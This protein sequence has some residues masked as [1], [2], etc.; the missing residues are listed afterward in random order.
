MAHGG[1]CV[2]RQDSLAVFVSGTLPGELVVAEVVARRSKLWFAR[3]VEVVEASP[4][5]VEHVWPLAGRAGVG[6]ADLGHVALT[7]Q[8]RW[9][10]EVV[11][12]QLRRI[13]HLDWAVEVAAAPGDEA[14][15]GLAYRTR[16]DLSADADGRLGM[17]PPRSDRVI[18]LDSM[19]LA[20]EDIVAVV[21]WSKPVAPGSRVRVLR[22]SGLG[23]AVVVRTADD[24]TAGEPA[25]LRRAARLQAADGP[26]GGGVALGGPVGRSAGH[27]GPADS[28]AAQPVTEEVVRAGQR[29]VYRLDPGDFWQ[30]HREAP[31]VLVEAVLDQAGDL[32]GRTVLDLYAGVGLFSVPLAA[33][34]RRLVAV[35]GDRSAALSAAWN[36]RDNP[37][38]T[39][40]QGDV[41]QLL[42][43]SGPVP[44]RA[45]VV[46]LDPPR[47]GAGRAVVEGVAARRPTA[48]VYVACDPA[49]LARDLG[50]FGGLGYRLDRLQAF[51]L[52]PH[53]HH[54]ECVATL[55]PG[56]PSRG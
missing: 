51:D 18:P 50:L 52:F 2:A 47:A 49:A 53:T 34:A 48:V 23:G 8:R 45:D 39:A 42:A 25:P 7:A 14:R 56:P 4:D 30:V 28:G 41:R 31:G 26:S 37:S 54:V 3:T 27:D 12:Q 20:H 43:R 55:S 38:A 11:V 44:A 1:W 40:V 10:A 19:P 36:L 13:A 46:V 21:P 29:L 6:G 16:L 33:A 5:R 22:T 35:E 24:P 9:K 17:H 32:A 15:G